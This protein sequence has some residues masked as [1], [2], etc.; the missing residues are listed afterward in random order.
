MTAPP[1][2]KPA[3][4]FVVYYMQKL[5]YILSFMIA[6][7]VMTA[8][9]PSCKSVKLTDADDTMARGEYLSLKNN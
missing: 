6:A 8:L 4:L 5:R 9:L 1:N 2:N 3:A 7:V